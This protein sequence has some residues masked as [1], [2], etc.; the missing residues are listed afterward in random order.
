MHHYG[1]LAPFPLVIAK[2]SNL[3]VTHA[4]SHPT[5]E[6]GSGYSGGMGVP[7]FVTPGWGFG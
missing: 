2:N 3:A 5:S 1:S 7:Q 4:A 6:V